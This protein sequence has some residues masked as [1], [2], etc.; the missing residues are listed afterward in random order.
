MVAV[1]LI[2]AS[3]YLTTGNNDKLSSDYQESEKLAEEYEKENPYEGS[4]EPY[5]GPNDINAAVQGDPSI[6]LAPI[7]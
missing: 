4:K 7:E 5:T 6:F 2:V 3:I 1:A